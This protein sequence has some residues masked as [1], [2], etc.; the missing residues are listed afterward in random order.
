MKQRAG[1][2]WSVKPSPD[3][4]LGDVEFTA[5]GRSMP[6]AGATR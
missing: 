3:T 2:G 5:P 4:K 1:N 6:P